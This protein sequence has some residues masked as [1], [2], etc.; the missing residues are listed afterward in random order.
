MSSS[1]DVHLPQSLILKQISNPSDR[2]DAIFLARYLAANMKCIIV[3]L[4]FE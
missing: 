2:S 4:G 3:R 1:S